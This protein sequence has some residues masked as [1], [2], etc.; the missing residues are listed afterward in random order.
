MHK[1]TQAL[2]SLLSQGVVISIFNRESALSCWKVILLQAFI[3]KQSKVG[4]QYHVIQT[5]LLM[6][7]L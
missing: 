6:H 7:V 5:T 4:K 2:I 1:C 3:C